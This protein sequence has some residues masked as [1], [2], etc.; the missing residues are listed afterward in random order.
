MIRFVD[1][2]G[3]YWT[4]P[5]HSSPICAF[6]STSDDRFYLALDGG[7]TFSSMEEITELG[8]HDFARR[9]AALVPDGFFEG[10]NALEVEQAETFIDYIEERIGEQL[11]ESY[12][13]G[14]DARQFLTDACNLLRRRYT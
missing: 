5:D 2:T 10:K 14:Q 12:Q 3:E 13:F 7:A 9:M 4:H 8:N 11:D 6:L 1:L